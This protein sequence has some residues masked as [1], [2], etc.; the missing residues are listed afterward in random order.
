M[1]TPVNQTLI[2]CTSST[3]AAAATREK[4][5]LTLLNRLRNI[6]GVADVTFVRVLK[7]K[8]RVIP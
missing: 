8:A 6:P 5:S 3:T 1:S 2:Y 4:V 7:E